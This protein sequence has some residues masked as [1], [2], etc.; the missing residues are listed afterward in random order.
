MKQVIIENIEDYN[1]YLK[2]KEKNDYKITIMFYDIELPK[3][4]DCLIINKELLKEKGILNLGLMDDYYGR[5]IENKKDKDLVI[6]IKDNK[7]I[8]LKKLYG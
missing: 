4:N 7:E 1:Y 5:N 8:Y 3:V 6:L 2:D